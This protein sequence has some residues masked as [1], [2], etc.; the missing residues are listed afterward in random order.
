MPEAERSF[1]LPFATLPGAIAA[2][3]QILRG[4]LQ[5]AA[6]DLLNPAAPATLGNSTWLLALRAGGNAAAMNR[7][8]REFAGLAEGHA[9]EDDRQ[10]TL[11]Q[12]IENFT[13]GVPLPARGWRRRARFV[14]AERLRNGDA[15]VPRPGNRARRQRGLLW[16]FRTR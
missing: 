8:E 1:L 11:W 13:P 4:Q 2:R 6:I 7:Y 16:L 9:F 10:V 14:Y 12:H 3:N 15:V 5:P